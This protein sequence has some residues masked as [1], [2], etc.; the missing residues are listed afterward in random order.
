MRGTGAQDVRDKLR[1]YLRAIYAETKAVRL[2]HRRA[3]VR[4]RNTGAPDDV[5]LVPE[6]RDEN[7]A[8]DNV[9]MPK[10]GVVLRRDVRFVRAI[11]ARCPN[12]LQSDDPH[13]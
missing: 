2:D 10:L 9:M 5:V 13:T 11:E 1:Q 12:V 3:Y 4:G 6:S 8:G 7:V